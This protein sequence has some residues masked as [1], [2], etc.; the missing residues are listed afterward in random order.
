MKLHLRSTSSINDKNNSYVIVIHGDGEVESPPV[1]INLASVDED[2]E[3][4]E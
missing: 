2:M 3:E 4:E 1:I